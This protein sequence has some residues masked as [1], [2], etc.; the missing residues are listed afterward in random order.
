MT[1]KS[2]AKPEKPEEP[3]KPVVA[4][5]FPK[6]PVVLGIDPGWQKTGV[7][8]VM[9]L[10]PGNLISKGV[11]L[12]RTS[13]EKERGERQA[14]ADF[15]RLWVFYDYFV[16]ALARLK[17]DAVGVECYTVFDNTDIRPQARTLL[18][19]ISDNILEDLVVKDG[20]AS[21][22]HNVRIANI[23]APMKALES[24]VNESSQRRGRGKA[25]KTLMVYTAAALACR[26]AGVK[27]Y[28]A[29]AGDLKRRVGDIRASKEDVITWVQANV[30]GMP[31]ALAKKK[32]P[33][34]MHEHVHDAAGH[35]VLALEKLILEP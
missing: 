1:K 4:K 21:V 25:A 33:R 5:V 8:A 16:D 2:E 7:A 31:E 22:Q 32:I 15:R 34:S 9:F 18:A 17:P 6:P 26:S 3:E 10:G 24:W 27:V 30:A 13:D 23:E 19:A 20:D 29:M 12:I 28:P 35:A 11:E 14:D